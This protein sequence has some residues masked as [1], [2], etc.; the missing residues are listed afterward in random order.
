MYKED[1][2]W[3]TFKDALTEKETFVTD[4][5]GVVRVTVF[6]LKEAAWQFLAYLTDDPLIKTTFT[7]NFKRP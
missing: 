2:Q 7:V 5:N 6:S 4:M 3:K 1:D